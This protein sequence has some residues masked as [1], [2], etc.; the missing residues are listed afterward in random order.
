MSNTPNPSIQ[1]TKII[2]FALTMSQFIY[3]VVG[4]NISPEVEEGNDIFLIVF[5]VIGLLQA[6]GAFLL[7]PKLFKVT[8]KENAF[9][10]CIV[11][12]ALIESIAVF[13]LVGKIL[14][15]SVT[16]MAG[17]LAMSIIFMLLLFPSDKRLEAMVQSD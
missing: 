11:Q 13:A 12:W 4:M 16:F 3:G 17:M 5:L 2:W 1:P 8:S 6:V 10:L 14:A 15:G 7:V 9:T